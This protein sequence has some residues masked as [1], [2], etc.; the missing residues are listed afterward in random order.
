MTS[1]WKLKNVCYFFSKI[2]ISQKTNIWNPIYGQNHIIRKNHLQVLKEQDYKRQTKAFHFY[3][4]YKSQQYKVWKL[5][6]SYT[7]PLPISKI[8]RYFSF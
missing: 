1:L 2:F 5:N 3:E 6:K 8:N 7:F 4:K